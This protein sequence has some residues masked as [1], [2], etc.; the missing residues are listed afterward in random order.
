M[1]NK[2]SN[3]CCCG[4]TIV[5]TCKIEENNLC[6]ICKT[7]GAKVKNIT[8][9]HLVL[10]TLSKLV[11]DT[12]YYLCMDEECDIVY[13]NT[14][15]NIKFNKQQVKVPIWFKK[16]ANPKYACYC[17]RITEEQVINAVIKDGARNIKD[18][19]NLTGAMKNAQ[20]Q[21]NNPLGKCCHQII[22][23]AVDKGLAMK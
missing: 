10:E 19:I 2:I 23:D 7:T 9:K 13:Y 21:K 17:S 18:V 8:V 12:D 3:K 16:D 22:Q 4:S 6:P 20:C 11:G 14:E 15:S 1:T 5:S